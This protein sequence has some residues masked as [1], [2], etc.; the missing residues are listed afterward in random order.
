MKFNRQNKNAAAP[1]KVYTVDRLT[2]RI[3]S[4]LEKDIGPVWVEGEVFQAAFPASGHVYLTLKD[5]HARLRA[6]IFRNRMRYLGFEPE[7]GMQVLAFGGLTV[8]EPRGEYQLVIDHLEPLGSGALA[9]AFEQLKTR[10]AAE[11]LFDEDRKKPLPVLPERICLITSPT[12]AAVHDFLNVIGRRFPGLK[13]QI[14]PVRVQGETAPEMIAQALADVAALPQP[15]QVV[16]VTRGG[17]SLEDLWAFNTETVARAVS[18]CPLPVV[19]A[20]GHEVDFTIIDFVADLRAPT[21]S[22]AA[23]MLIA[24]R[25]E[26]RQR[27][28]SRLDRLAALASARLNRARLE[29]SALERRLTDP[30]RLLSHHRL[31]VGMLESQLTRAMTGR[32]ERLSGRA[33]AAAARLAGSS[34]LTRLNDRRY[35]TRT[36]SDQLAWLTRTRLAVERSRLARS[37]DRL[38]ALSPLAVLGRGYSLT[39]GPDGR[40][41]T[42]ADRVE[43]GDEIKVRL[44]RGGLKAR[45]EK[46][47]PDEETDIRRK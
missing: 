39:F 47:L 35:R 21:P 9:L 23:E 28:E 45:V 37:V 25:T 14:C 3:R 41:L 7:E 36:L 34:P 12:G 43:P 4:V 19:S 29:L 18:A 44:R 24:S 17:G 1:P 26:W 40:L 8:Y 38:Q 2:A 5:D 32:L 13:I 31:G 6:V 27:F 33:S 46:R 30:G 22:A 11:G 42:G 10:L 20:V 16:V 15:P